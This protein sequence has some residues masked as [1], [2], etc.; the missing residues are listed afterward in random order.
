[1]RYR[2]VKGLSE[3]EFRRLTG[4]KRGTFDAMLEALRKAKRKARRK[5]GA[6]N[7]LALA[8]RLLMTLGS[9]REYR[10]YFHIGLDYG[11]DETVALRN[12]RAIEDALAASGLFALPGRKALLEGG[13]FEAVIVDATETPVERP[14]KSSAAATPAKRSAIR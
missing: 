10:T 14:K 7:K 8:D 3:A 6:P 1:M 9:W 13:G 12:I 4:V 2:A 5:G 11:V